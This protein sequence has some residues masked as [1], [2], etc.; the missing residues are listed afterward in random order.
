M[1][2]LLLPETRFH[3]YDVNN[4]DFSALPLPMDAYFPSMAFYR[5]YHTYR[6]SDK[7]F[8]AC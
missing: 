1:L 3:R 7:S 5:L 4:T 8:D 2:Y 6:R